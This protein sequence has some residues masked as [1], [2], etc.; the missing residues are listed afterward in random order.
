MA[1]YLNSS[2]RPKWPRITANKVCRH[3]YNFNKFRTTLRQ[4]GLEIKIVLQRV[5]QESFWASMPS[6]NPTHL[7]PEWALTAVLIAGKCIS[8]TWV[9]TV[10]IVFTPARKK[11]LHAKTVHQ[12]QND[13]GSL[14]MKCAD[15]ATTSIFNYGFP[16]LLWFAYRPARSAVRSRGRVAK[17]GNPVKWER[18]G[19]WSCR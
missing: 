14:L 8:A 6:R 10:V 3:G 15:M 11:W 9:W 17:E 12:G 4:R 18:Q 2:P 7:L 16:L 5:D 13:Q 1:T 19:T